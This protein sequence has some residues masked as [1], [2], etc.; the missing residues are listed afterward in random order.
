MS[1]K[2]NLFKGKCVRGGLWLQA[3]VG[4]RNTSLDLP[5]FPSVCLHSFIAPPR[6]QGSQLKSKGGELICFH[7]YCT[8]SNLLRC[9]LEMK[10]INMSDSQMSLK[11]ISVRQLPVRETLFIHSFTSSSSM[12]VGAPARF[13]ACA[14]N[15][16]Y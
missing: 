7:F 12:L 15:L 8:V 11:F 16:G 4:C 3:V 13:Q 2:P 1:N 5:D 10:I 9:P 6:K 14:Q